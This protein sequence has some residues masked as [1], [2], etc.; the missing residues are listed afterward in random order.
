MIDFLS[1]KLHRY[2][3]RKDERTESWTFLEHGTKLQFQQTNTHT[4][5]Y[6]CVYIYVCMYNILD[7]NESLHVK[8][9]KE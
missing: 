7:E 9:K 2:L 6:V 1:E 3:W 4:N 5:K 8:W